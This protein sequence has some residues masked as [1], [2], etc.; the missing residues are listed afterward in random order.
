MMCCFENIDIVM[1]GILCGNYQLCFCIFNVF[2]VENCREFVL[3]QISVMFWGDD[4]FE[5][6]L[7]VVGEVCQSVV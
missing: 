3:Q 2:V 7:C 6:M 1:V 4:V 5:V